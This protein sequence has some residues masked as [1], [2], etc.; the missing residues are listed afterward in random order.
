MYIQEQEV[1]AII[2]DMDGLIFDNGLFYKAAYQQAAQ[3][4]GYYISD[5]MYK[6]FLG[7]THRAC[8]AL[9]KKAFG[10]TF[11]I[12]TFAQLLEQKYQRM[13][14]Q[15]GIS[16]R[17]GFEALFAY[18]QQCDIPVGLATSSSMTHVK[19]HLGCTV[20]FDMLAAICTIDDV[21]RGKPDP[22]IY[23]LVTKQMQVVP[24]QALVFEDSNPGMRAAIAAGCTSVMI[25]NQAPPEKDI[26]SQAYL[27]ASSLSDI[28]PLFKR[29]R[30]VSNS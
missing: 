26:E 1:K 17:E 14:L 18:A 19:L 22:E 6:Q 7:Q 29:Q 4:M 15:E 12:E 2:F 9:L 8:E 24:K 27:I 28:I 20:Y 21:Q 16:F 13:L 11:F 3:E 5:E 30:G 10:H 23:Q 25:P